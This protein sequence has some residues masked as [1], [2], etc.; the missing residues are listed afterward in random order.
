MKH[1]LFILIG[2]IV[3]G[4]V[5]AATELSDITALSLSLVNQDPDPVSAGDIVEV[6]VG[7]QNLGGTAAADTVVM[8]APKYP[9]SLVEGEDVTQE[10]GTIGAYQNDQN[11]QIVKFKVRVDRDATAGTYD[12]DFNYYSRGSKTTLAKAVPITV[13]S[14]E[15]AEVILIDRTMLI[16]GKETGV[17]FTIHNVGSAPLRD[18]TFYWTNS[19]KVI[20]PVGSDNTRYIKYIDV[21]DKVDLEYHVIADTNADAGLYALNLYL[22]YDDTVRNGTNTITT[23][24]GIYVGGG[25]DFDVAYAESSGGDTS[26]SIA[27]VGS[28]PA[29][30]VSVSVPQQSAWK[31]SGSNSM[32]IGNLNKGDYTV[33]SFTLQSGRTFQRNSTGT[34]EQGSATQQTQ[35]S[36]QNTPVTLQ[37]A[38]TD[39]MGQRTI[40][41]KDVIIATSALNMTGGA[42]GRSG[43]SRQTSSSSLAYLWYVG[44]AVVLIIGAILYIRHRRKRALDLES[45]RRR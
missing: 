31:V 34:P 1:T 42:T 7:V 17:N 9:F 3:I 30:S 38:Y 32:I 12:L 29:Y 21:G 13:E 41:T 16:P 35:G 28:N 6:R 33:A 20:L 26:F 23:V 22:T 36:S 4:S 25:T 43:Y 2:C 14:Q 24:A 27:N 10:I 44:G 19:D 8:V 5:M 40:V 37:I 15:S 11:M 18:L 39:T 45:K